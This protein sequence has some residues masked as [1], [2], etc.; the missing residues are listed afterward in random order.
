VYPRIAST[1]LD[2][3]NLQNTSRRG[4]TRRYAL[5][6]HFGRLEEESC[7][8]RQA[9]RLGGLEIED[10][11]EGRGLLYGEVRGPRPLE[12]LVD[13]RGE[14]FEVGVHLRAIRDQPPG[15]HEASQPVNR[16]EVVR[17]GE[18]RDAP[19]VAPIETVRLDQ[20][21]VRTPRRERG[22][23]G[24]EVVIGPRFERDDLLESQH[25]RGVLRFAKIHG[26]VGLI[27]IA[28]VGDAHRGRDQ[29][30]FSVKT[31]NFGR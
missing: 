8:D 12:N 28:E 7:G 20:Q 10:E 21:C 31:R 5:A 26:R 16:G 24:V 6:E 25:A 4:G 2:R 11:L 1:D 14:P 17:Q 23:C 9:K 18:L 15:L 13:V 27:G 22:E 3:F 19:P 29:L 30:A